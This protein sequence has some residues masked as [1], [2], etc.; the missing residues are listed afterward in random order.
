MSEQSKCPICSQKVEPDGPYFGGSEMLKCVRCGKYEIGIMARHEISHWSQQQRVN[1]SGFVR[2]NQGCNIVSSN[3]SQFKN[4]PNLTVG[5]SAEKIMMLL[6][7]N[8]TRP[9]E[10]ADLSSNTYFE[11]LAVGRLTKQEELRFFLHDYLYGERGF[12]LRHELVTELGDDSRYSI[13]PKGWAYIESLRHKNVDS[14]I[15]FIAM[16]FDETVNDAWLAIDKAIRAAGY[17]PLRIDQKHHNNKIDDEIIA[18]IR[19]SK[20]LVADF[21]GQRGGVYFE[22]GFARGLWA[23]Q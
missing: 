20:F 2:E 12:L 17:E 23:C 13:S 14:Q 19:R 6:A 3:L 22:A 9:G 5:E 16:W 21:T 18:A 4:L 1:L 11:C 8:F 7:K 10:V 15:S